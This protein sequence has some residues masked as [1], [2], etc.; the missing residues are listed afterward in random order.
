ME[1]K[2][3]GGARPGAGRKKKEV[4]KEV[5]LLAINAIIEVYGSVEAGFKNLLKSGEPTLVKFAWGHAVGNPKDTM[6]IDMKST[7]ETI[8]V[9]KLPSNN[10][11]EK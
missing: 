2:S 10:R 9:V 5:R 1:K 4:E 11:D 8:Q 7:V 6:D 3:K